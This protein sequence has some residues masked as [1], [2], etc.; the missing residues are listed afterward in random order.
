MDGIDYYGYVDPIDI[1]DWVFISYMSTNPIETYLASLRWKSFV[2]AIVLA[3]ILMLMIRDAFQRLFLNRIIGLEKATRDY[4]DHREFVIPNPGKDEIGELAYSF[5]ELVQSLEDGKTK[6]QNQSDELEKEVSRRREAQL[7]LE[8]SEGKFRALF[9]QSPDA[10]V[11]LD[12]DTWRDCNQAAL[13]LLQSSDRDGLIQQRMDQLSPQFQPDG[14]DSKASWALHVK[15]AYET[16]LA[17]FEWVILTSNQETVWIDVL[18]TLIPY[19]GAEVLYA[20]MRDIRARKREEVER[21]R[22][23]TAIEQAAESILVTDTN[24]IILYVNP[25]F[26]ELNGYSRDAI[27]GS[28]AS[29]M[30]GENIDEKSIQ[31]MLDVAYQGKVWKGRSTHR[32]NDGTEYQAE[33]T[34]S[35]VKD[36]SGNV[37]NVV[38]VFRD[39]SKEAAMESQLRQAQK[40]EAI[41]ELASGIAHEINTPTQYVGGNIRFFRDSFS[42]IS[43]LLKKVRVILEPTLDAE[44]ASAKR[45]EI[46]AY[47]EEIDLEYLEEELPIAISQSLEGNSRVAEI[48]RAM[49]E[50]AH[51]GNEELTAIDVNHTIQNTISV[52]R[53]EWKYVA[54]IETDLESDLPL[55]PCFPGSFNQVI[56]NMFVN[57]AH[58]ISEVVD[59]GDKGK[60]VIRVST[61]EDKGWIEVR[62]SDTGCGIPEKNRV[63]IF[64]PLFTTKAIGKGTGQGLSMAHSVIVE[65]HQGTIDLESTVG[66]GTTFIIRIPL[67]AI[68]LDAAG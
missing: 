28:N 4:A 8:E 62:I 59:G 46:R 68:E 19:E 9:D 41:G 42:D 25:A 21:V 51:P 32:K 38:Y 43:E 6:I 30:Y 65:K 48:V 13:T 31:D 29:S 64:D 40:M 35:P 58:A 63:K 37:M 14:Q 53:N 49:K 7:S 17:S 10:I 54:E 1:N 26:L 50:F 67:E 3:I 23:T 16:G 57:A 24:G 5:Q 33:T 22:L 20:V 61:R 27:I 56:L 12:N 60:G 39:V 34:I 2:A 18:L 52:A 66:E 15:S 55:T 44:E 11:L 36:A 47:I 45:D